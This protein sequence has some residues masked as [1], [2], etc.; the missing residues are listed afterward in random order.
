[1]SGEN[2]NLENVRVD[3]KLCNIILKRKMLK[4]EH[5]FGKEDEDFL[6]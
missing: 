4:H 5:H 3:R 2:K 1:M 6:F